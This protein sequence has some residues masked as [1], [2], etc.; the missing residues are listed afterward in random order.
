MDK[1]SYRALREN[2]YVSAK[3]E[4]TTAAPTITPAPTNTGVNSPV[5]LNVVKSPRNHR[6]AQ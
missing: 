3:R 1:K 5:L 4:I 6:P 2:I